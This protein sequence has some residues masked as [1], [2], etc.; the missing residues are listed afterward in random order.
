[1]NESAKLLIKQ[2][3]DPR[4]HRSARNQ[5]IKKGAVAVDELLVALDQDLPLSQKKDLMRILLELNDSRSAD[6]FRKSLNSEDEEIRSI[7]ATGFH[8]AHCLCPPSSAIHSTLCAMP[9]AL[10]PPFPPSAF[11]LPPS[12]FSLPHSHFQIQSSFPPPNSIRFPC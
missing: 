4:K 5:L 10:C 8:Q 1:M 12:N 7:S 9:F 6:L 3:S 11:P 2:L